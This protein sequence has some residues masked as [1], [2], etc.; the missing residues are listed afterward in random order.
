MKRRRHALTKPNCPRVS[1]QCRAQQRVG[2]R[3]RRTACELRAQRLGAPELAQRLESKRLRT[4]AQRR[5][6]LGQC[7]RRGAAGAHRLHD[8]RGRLQQPPQRRR[9]RG[10]APARA[11]AVH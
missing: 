3:G 6:D 4:A 2:R 9:R 11:R 5:I 10:G 8:L 7:R 1:G